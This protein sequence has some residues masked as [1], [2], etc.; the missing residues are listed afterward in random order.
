MVVGCGVLWCCVCFVMGCFV[1]FFFKA[2]DVFWKGTGESQ[3]LHFY[4]ESL[5][6]FKYSLILELHCLVSLVPL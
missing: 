5:C 1:C 6:T 3:S 2:G 4:L